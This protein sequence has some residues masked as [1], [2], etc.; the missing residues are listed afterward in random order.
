MVVHKVVIDPY[1][2]GMMLNKST[3]M[4]PTCGNGPI[5]YLV[6]SIVP[7]AIRTVRFKPAPASVIAS[8]VPARGRDPIKKICK[9]IF[10]IFQ[11]KL[12]I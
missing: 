6:S 7:D 3:L 12:N 8:I 9:L 4:S 11:K 5:G 1:T 10:Y 2:A